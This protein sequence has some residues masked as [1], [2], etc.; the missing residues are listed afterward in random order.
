MSPAARCR[1]TEVRFFTEAG[2]VD[3]EMFWEEVGRVAREGASARLRVGRDGYPAARTT[4]WRL[5]GRVVARL[6]RARP[7][8]RVAQN[9]AAGGRR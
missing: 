4:R 7:A 3:E 6:V 5:R 8:R 1:R 2:R 9:T